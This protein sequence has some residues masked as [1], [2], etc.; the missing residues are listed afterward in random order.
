MANNLP[1]AMSPL[2]NLQGD[3]AQVPR[4]SGQ[5]QDLLS[6]INRLLSG[7]LSQPGMGF[8]PIAEQAKSQFQEQTI[9]SIAERF[10]AMGGTG[11]LRDSAF[12]QSL[13]QAGAG[14]NRDLASMQSQYNMGMFA[15]LLQAGLSPQ[16]ET[17][18]RPQG[19]SLGSSLGQSLASGLGQSI[20]MGALLALLKFLI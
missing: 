16:Y 15:P 12:S 2:G 19:P 4:Y 17:M 13:G 11:S 14:L 9:P 8:G 20:P 1:S 6:Q 5:Q 7:Q 10:T 3:I 18:F